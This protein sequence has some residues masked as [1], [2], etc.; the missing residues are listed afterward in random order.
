MDYTP[1][2]ID[3]VDPAQTFQARTFAGTYTGL[4]AGTLSDLGGAG[5]AV[6][7]ARGTIADAAGVDTSVDLAPIEADLAASQDA[8]D[9]DLT[10]LQL[11][12]VAAATDGAGPAID[13]GLSASGAASDAHNALSPQIDD[14]AAEIPPTQVPL[15]PGDTDTPGD[16]DTK[17]PQEH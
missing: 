10:A 6:D 9:A 5:G 7:D 3:P 8:D 11:D 12:D 14:G 2:P 16:W 17:P 4:V 13:A 1:G 15:G